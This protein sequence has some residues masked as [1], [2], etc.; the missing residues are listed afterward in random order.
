MRRKMLSGRDAWFFRAVILIET[1]TYAASFLLSGL[2]KKD[3]FNRLEGKETTLG[4]SSLSVLILLNTAIPLAINLVKQINAGLAAK[5]ESRMRKNAKLELLSGVLNRRPGDGEGRKYGETV[6]LYRNECEDLVSCRM[7][8]YRQLPRLT[9]C[10]A[11]LAVMLG[12]NPLFAAISLIPALLILL[13]I[14]RLDRRILMWR[15]TARKSTSEVTEFLE[16]VFGHMEYFRLAAGREKMEELFREKCERRAD[17]EIRD[18]LLDGILSVISENAS[19]FVL[20]IVLLTA[21]PLYQSGRLSVGELVMFEYYYAFLA[22]LPD[23][24]GRLIL[25]RRQAEVAERRLKAVN[26]EIPQAETQ[27]I[28]TLPQINEDAAFCPSGDLRISVDGLRG[29]IRL[30]VHPGEK[31]LISGGQEADRSRMLRRLFQVCAEHL[32]EVPAAYVPAEPVLFQTSI[33][34]NI[35]FGEPFFQERLDLVMELAGLKEDFEKEDR[36][37][38]ERSAGKMGAALSGGQKK[39]IGIARALYTCMSRCASQN[40]A[41]RYLLFIDGLTEA[42]DERTGEYLISHVLNRPDAI[43]FVA[44]DSERLRGCAAQILPVQ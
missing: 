37:E 39:R 22:S 1:L 25:R 32:P 41:A 40:G 28:G 18:R 27:K 26:D 44:S 24:A 12:V 38:I 42:V 4:I 23:S 21:L 19:A 13:L 10:A 6:S 14:R 43:A 3:I 30:S 8:Y 31:V 29:P 35:C 9:L 5:A 34:D 33:R 11:I 16:N 7:E 36:N 15:E 17:R 20:G 2:A